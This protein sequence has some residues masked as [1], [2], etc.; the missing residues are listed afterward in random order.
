MSVAQRMEFHRLTKEDGLPSNSVHCIFKD[1]QGFMWMGTVNGLCRYDGYEFKLYN[2]QNGYALPDDHINDIFQDSNG[3]IWI[4]TNS[5]GVSILNPKTDSI[6]T[7]KH[8][9]NNPYS[10]PGD[11][12]RK[13]VE[14]VNGK[15]WIGFDNGIGLSNLDLKTGKAKNYDP[16][17]SVEKKGVKAIRAIV[18]DQWRPDTLWLATTSGLIAFDSK[19]ERFHVID[20]PLEKI[21]RHGLFAAYQP[22]KNTIL[23]GFYYA[24]IDEYQ[25][26]NGT[27]NESYSDVDEN[28]RTFDIAKK[29]NTEYWLAARKKGLAIYETQEKEIRFIPSD[30]DNHKSPFPGFTYTVVTD[31]EKLWVGGVN[32]VSFYDGDAHKF[33]FVPLNFAQKEYGRITVAT[34]E[35]DKIYLAGVSGE[36]LWEIDKKTKNQRVIV[37]G[38]SDMVYGMLELEDK[39]IIIDVLRSLK[40][41][42]KAS[43]EINPLQVKNMPESEIVMQSIHEW[44]SEYALILTAYSGV[45]KL[46][47]VTNEISPLFKINGQNTPRYHDMLI[48]SDR[49]IWFSTDQ[50]IVIYDPRNNSTTHFQPESIS[51][52]KNQLI[53]VVREDENLVKWIGSSNGLI[54][55]ENDEEELINISNSN[56]PSNRVMEILFDENQSMWLG[57][58]EGIS[59]VDPVNG[60]IINYNKADGLDHAG[61]FVKIDDYL[62][63]GSYGGYSMFHPDSIQFSFDVPQVYFTDFKVRN[64]DYPLQQSLDY[65]EQIN[66]SYTEN[67]FS[68]GFTSPAL[69]P[70]QKVQFAYQLEGLDE[71]WISS[72]RSRQANYTNLDGGNYLFKVKAR[73]RDG[74]WSEPRTISIFIGTPFWETWWFYSICGLLIVTSGFVFYKVRIRILE[75]RAE[76]EAQELRFEALQKRLQELNATPPDINLDIDD[77]NDKLNTPLSEREFEVLKLSLDGKTNSEI[78]EELFI[79]TSTVKFHLRNTYGKLGVNNRKEALDYV[80]KAP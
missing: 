76:L 28:I 59:K 56:L 5:H 22:D 19:K 4:G 65:V 12:V 29:S 1:Q 54:K 23:G 69:S 39:V 80:V 49:K 11:R 50:D 73:N 26:N 77:L 70:R 75:H 64:Q 53:Y 48:A 21:N 24:G 33:P 43:G 52:K 30:M 68:F 63:V 38:M 32:G 79:S 25:I 58:N 10:I 35:Y 3:L 7:F 62:L 2:Q 13:I 66:L 31:E 72:E 74:A 17:A 46:N 45:Y 14:D 71:D 6:T 47:L 55:L 9:P 60:E 41:L 61:C 40:Y 20:H 15:I 36:G 51:S 16:F 8:D 42:D 44:T 27:W 18:P 37:N 34:G 78:G 57:T 67:F